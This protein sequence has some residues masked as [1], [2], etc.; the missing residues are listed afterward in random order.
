MKDDGMEFAEEFFYADGLPRSGK[1]LARQ[2]AR[3]VVALLMVFSAQN[4]DYK[5]PGGG[6]NRNETPMEAL[7]REMLEEC[8]ATVSRIDGLLGTVTE[9][10]PAV[11]REYDVFKMT[12]YYFE[13]QVE[14]ALA[15]QSLDPYE[16]SLGLRPQWVEIGEALERNRRVLRGEFGRV[17][18]WTERETFV[19][20]K[21]YEKVCG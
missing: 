7:R 4:G 1:I 11:E 14:Q 19:L 12:S 6:V 13:C 3:G 9:Y 15:D 17:P 10:R 21:L 16:E 5:F 20:L 2:A 18:K 8:G